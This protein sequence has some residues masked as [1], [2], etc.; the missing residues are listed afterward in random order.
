VPRNVIVDM[1]ADNLRFVHINQLVERARDKAKGEDVGVEQFTEDAYP[2]L[3]RKCE[4]KI[5]DCTFRFPAGKSYP[6]KRP[7]GGDQRLRS[8]SN[9][10]AT[11][12]KTS[13]SFRPKGKHHPPGGASDSLLYPAVWLRQ[14]FSSLSH[15][16]TIAGPS[17]KNR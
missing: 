6:R 16:K 17:R 2:Q 3:R 4:E 13:S 14:A 9:H 8:P 12:L 7:S 5:A 1:M 15:D 10:A 11:T